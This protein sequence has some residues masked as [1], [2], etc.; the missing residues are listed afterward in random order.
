MSYYMPMDIVIEKLS[1][2]DNFNAVNKSNE[3][4]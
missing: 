2:F 1:T 3:I 4:C